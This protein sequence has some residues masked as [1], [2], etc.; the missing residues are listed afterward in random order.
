MI[1]NHKIDSWHKYFA[2]YNKNKIALYYSSIARNNII[3]CLNNLILFKKKNINNK[4]LDF[5]VSDSINQDSNPF[6]K[7]FLKKKRDNIYGCGVD[8]PE[9]VMKNYKE[10]KY[11]R[12]KP[13]TKLPYKKNFFSLSISHAVFEH[14]GN[15]TKKK[16]YLSELIRISDNVFISI[17]N[18]YF[19]IE[20]HSNIPM[21]G[22]LPSKLIYK[23]LSF[24]NYNLFKNEK[25]LTFNSK[26]KF[27]KI[28]TKLKKKYNIDFHLGY[29]GLKFGIFSSHFYIFIKKIKIK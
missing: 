28:A 3:K 9:N 26:S 8:N 29:T 16:F 6:V 23:I 5:G 17:P 12:I 25:N 22:Y 1:K 13:Y 14:I 19:P 11:K 18:R 20:H 27:F 15:E 24:F 10:L 4:I 7:F 2:K 21:L